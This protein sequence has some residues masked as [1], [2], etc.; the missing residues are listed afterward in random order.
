MLHDALTGCLSSAADSQSSP[1][2]LSKDLSGVVIFAS[3][4]DGNLIESDRLFHANIT[5]VSIEPVN[6]TL[7]HSALPL[8]AETLPPALPTPLMQRAVSSKTANSRAARRNFI[9]EEDERNSFDLEFPD[10]G[11]GPVPTF[12][13]PGNLK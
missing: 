7:R 13:L 6:D 4:P 1:S 11:E 9:R 3:S 12:V 5:E 8:R 2:P 10:G